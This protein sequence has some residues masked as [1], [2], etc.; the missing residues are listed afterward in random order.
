MPRK[1]PL[2][3]KFSVEDQA[4]VTP[5]NLCHD[6]GGFALSHEH[7]DSVKLQ[8]RKRT[9]LGKVRW[10]YHAH[11]FAPTCLSTQHGLNC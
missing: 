11:L 1:P 9:E 10:S 6:T 7:S 4:K 2:D 5:L 8:S 3:I